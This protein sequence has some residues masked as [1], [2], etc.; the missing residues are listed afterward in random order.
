MTQKRKREQKK[1]LDAAEGELELSP[2]AMATAMGI[3]YHSYKDL[4]SGRRMLRDIHERMV[5]ALKALKIPKPAQSLVFRY[6]TVAI[7]KLACPG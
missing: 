3:P 7:R 1:L 5:K 2:V 6:G 4:K